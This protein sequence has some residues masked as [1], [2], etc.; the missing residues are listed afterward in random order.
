MSHTKK[1][2]KIGTRK[3][4]LAVT[5]SKLIQSLLLEKGLQTELV[6]IDSEGDKNQKEA[7]YKLE[8]EPGI[9]TKQ[10]ETALLSNTIDLA[11]HSLKDLPTELPNALQISALLDRRYISDVL[12]IHRNF[13]DPKRELGLKEGT[14][15]GSSSLRREAQLYAKVSDITVKPI[16]G[17]VPTRI[18]KLSKLEYGAIVLAEAGITRLN[19]DLSQYH[20]V[21]LEVDFFVPAPGQG[22]LAVETKKDVDR[23]VLEALKLLHHEPTAI[24]VT[25]ERKILNALEGGCSLPL[26]VYCRKQNE[27]FT[28]HAFLGRLTAAEGQSINERQWKTFHWVHYKSRHIEDLQQHVLRSLRD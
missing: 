14:I 9:F 27:E 26:G 20:V 1:V 22:T 24:E 13:Y 16:R 5:Q 6:Y 4:D 18:E 21:K 28:I 2:Y 10:L 8:V 15:V 23:E 11:V 3:S 17:N 25:I 12:V 7:L 19:L